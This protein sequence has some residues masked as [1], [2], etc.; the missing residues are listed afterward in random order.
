[1]CSDRLK[2]L[3]QFIQQKI[4]GEKCS[5]LQVDKE[6]LQ[7]TREKSVSRFVLS[8]PRHNMDKLHRES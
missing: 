1:M 4:G 6:M 5:N 8:M 3:G 2:D 7:Q